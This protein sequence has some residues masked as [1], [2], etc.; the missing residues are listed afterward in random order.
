MRTR[1]IALALAGFVAYAALCDGALAA[2]HVRFSSAVF[3][4]LVL[5]GIFA[6]RRKVDA[7]IDRAAHA[8]LRWFA[9]LFVPACVGAM[10]YGTLL[11]RS[12]LGVTV[13]LVLST[14]IGVAVAAGV[15]T[16]VHRRVRRC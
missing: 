5:L 6:L 11:A 1:K 15:G 13:T 3:G 4:M 7:P 12:W 10:Q 14:L 8:L 9:L 2:L 16:L